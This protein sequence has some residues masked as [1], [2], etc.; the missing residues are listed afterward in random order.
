MGVSFTPLARQDLAD[1]TDFIARDN[2]RRAILF[3]QE[4]VDA[5]AG[6]AAQP[7]R[8]AILSRYRRFH[9]RRRPLGHYAIIYRVK[10]GDVEIIR[11]VSSWVDLD[12]ALDGI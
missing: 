4:L 10:A 8:Y 2:P 3:V 7:E 12:A 6:L 11:V 9:L 5:C 1:I